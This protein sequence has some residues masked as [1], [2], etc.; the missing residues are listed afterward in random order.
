MKQQLSE[1]LLNKIKET[2]QESK[3]PALEWD[4]DDGLTDNQINKI[5]VLPNGMS[6]VEDEI[7]E[8]NLDYIY[9]LQNE[10]VRR[11]IRDS[12]TPICDELGWIEDEVTDEDIDNLIDEYEFRYDCF[13]IE[14]NIAQLIS[15]SRPKVVLQLKL[16][17]EH[18]DFQW[19]STVE[20]GDVKEVLKFFNINPRKIHKTF[21]NLSYR[22]GKEF[23]L[24]KDLKELWDNA[25]YG[26]QYVIPIDLD[27]ED[28][29]KNRDHYHTGIILH[30]GSKIWMHDYFNGSGSIDIP[31]QKDLTILKS[32][33]NYD[34]GDDG[35]TAGYGLNEVY[36]LS[37]EAWDNYISPLITSSPTPQIL[38]AVDVVM[39]YFM[40]GNV[41]ADWQ[42]S[43]FIRA[44]N[45]DRPKWNGEISEPGEM[46]Q[47]DIRHTLW[48]DFPS[49]GKKYLKEK[50]DKDAKHCVFKIKELIGQV[51]IIH[52][53]FIV[54]DKSKKLV[55]SEIGASERSHE[56]YN[57]LKEKIE[58]MAKSPEHAGS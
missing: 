46:M 11:I 5:L 9:F 3:S 27:L 2:I 49:S 34:F 21:P 26:G 56:I 19:R 17:H 58:K 32:K 25:C 41:L 7:I 28:Y 38:P 8:N 4:H 45:D 48:D 22:N 10:H 20:Y 55:W 57:F 12:L 37:R 40:Y 14:S 42:F 54:H 35:Q 18:Q 36:G 23:L 33:L 47:W 29:S 50:A 1:P 39:Q 6:E 51:K 31:L 44:F 13:E 43:G 15:N 52:C 30:K 16:Y 53:Q 24:S